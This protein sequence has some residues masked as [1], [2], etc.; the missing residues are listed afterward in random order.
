MQFYFKESAI[1]ATKNNYLAS[2][3][4]ADSVQIANEPKFTIAA[5]YFHS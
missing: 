2:R 5:I 1:S 3:K 4:I